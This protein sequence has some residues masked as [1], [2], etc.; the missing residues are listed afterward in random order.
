MFDD[1]EC[2]TEGA[3]FGVSATLVLAT[4]G[5]KTYGIS[6]DSCFTG[7]CVIGEFRATE[8]SGGTGLSL[9]PSNLSKNIFVFGGNS[10]RSIATFHVQ[11][12]RNLQIDVVGG[13]AKNLPFL[14][15]TKVAKT[16]R[17]TIKYEPAV[18]LFINN[19]RQTTW[20]APLPT[21]DFRSVI[22]YLHKNEL[23]ILYTVLRT[24]ASNAENVVD[25]P[26]TH[27]QEIIS[28][29]D[30]SDRDAPTEAGDDTVI[31]NENT[32]N[33]DTN[34]IPMP[35]TRKKVLAMH[36]ATHAN[37]LRLYNT[38]SQ[39]LILNPQQKGVLKE[40]C[41]SAQKECTACGRFGKKVK[42]GTVLRP[43]LVK[44]ERGHI[45]LFCLDSVRDVWSLAVVDEG[46]RWIAL[47]V[48]A[49]KE[50]SDV[51]KAYITSYGSVHGC[52][53]FLFS[54]GDGC[55]NSSKFLSLCDAFGIVKESGPSEASE[56]FGIV[57]RAIGTARLTL[58]RVGSDPHGP[59]TKEE[60]DFSCQLC[61]NGIRNEIRSGG[62]TA[63]QR[64][65]GG[66][67]HL[68]SNFLNQLDT[69]IG[70]VGA[71]HRLVSIKE[72]TQKNFFAALNSEKLTQI[73][74]Q[75]GT[76]NRKVL[77]E[78]FELGELIEF[79]REIE[80]GRGATWRIGRIVGILPSE[81]GVLYFHIDIGGVL[82]RVAPRHIR[83]SS[84]VPVQELPNL[85]T[86]FHEHGGFKYGQRRGFEEEVP[87]PGGGEFNPHV[88]YT[89]GART[90]EGGTRTPPRDPRDFPECGRCDHGTLSEPCLSDF[91]DG[92]V[93]KHKYLWNGKKYATADDVR[94][95]SKLRNVIG[96]NE[97]VEKMLGLLTLDNL[98][99]D[100]EP[101]ELVDDSDSEDDIQLAQESDS[102]DDVEQQFLYTVLQGAV[103]NGDFGNCVVDLGVEDTAQS[104]AKENSQ[105]KNDT[106]QSAAK[107]KSK[108]KVE[109]ILVTEEE[110]GKAE[111]D[112]G[113][114]WLGSAQALKG[115]D[116]YAHDFEELPEKERID[117]QLKAISD[118]D[119]F[120]CWDR[121]SDLSDAEM[122]LHL[123]KSKTAVKLTAG[124]VNKCKV[125]A[126]VLAGKSRYT[127][128]GF[129]DAF[130]FSDDCQSPTV[131][132]LLLRILLIFAL[133]YQWDFV[134][135][136]FSQA[137][138]QT[139]TQYSRE[140]WVAI[141]ELDGDSFRSGKRWRLLLKPVPGTNAAPRGWFD[142][143]SK[144]F[145]GIGF[146]QSRYDKAIFLL[147]GTCEG[148]NVFKMFIPLHVD[149]ALVCG[150]RDT[151]NWFQKLVDSSVGGRWKV[152]TFVFLENNVSTEFV[153]SEYVLQNRNGER[154][155]Q[156]SQDKYCQ[157]K[158]REVDQGLV[159]DK[160]YEQSYRQALGTALWATTHSQS[161]SAYDIALAAQKVNDLSRTDGAALN[162][163]IREMRKNPM[164][165]LI[166]TLDMNK[167]L[168]IITIVDAGMGDS[169]SWVGGQG[170]C[171][172]GLAETD[173]N[174]EN[175][176]SSHFKFASVYVKSGKFKRT[177]GASFDGECIV[178]KDGC[179]V[180]IFIQ[181]FISELE[182][183]LRLNIAQTIERQVS[184]LPEQ[185]R[186]L[187]PVDLFTDSF[188]L[189]R[190]MRA[191]FNTADLSKRRVED[192]SDLR[193]C[194]AFNKTRLHHV[195][196]TS[197][198]T[199]ALTKV[200]HKCTATRKILREM[201]ESG[202]WAPQLSDV[203]LG[204]THKAFPKKK[205]KKS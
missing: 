61:A 65:M 83:K 172:I 18:T 140:V 170:G 16:L 145:I 29:P 62:S 139:T 146:V 25:I 56:S 36:A 58:D 66:D 160:D 19:V 80:K 186:E 5:Q 76:R 118:Y 35:I 89:G 103:F 21:I 109:N 81:D 119:E 91:D 22:E 126:G 150:D 112:M 155:L 42:A 202:K 163:S 181:G 173:A 123:V 6:A 134:S 143:I 196:G 166:P 167:S 10:E 15:G 120:Q 189:V 124:F 200:F 23:S 174:A 122:D 57:E 67:S 7:G 192:L 54:D 8:L 63:S 79:Y 106:A 40:W 195:D 24:N 71:S 14:F 74:K 44:N 68:F 110:K 132:A 50:S 99:G 187:S 17:L 148:K 64:A 78:S 135:I 137:F 171:V 43:S 108:Y 27:A 98:E 184:G 101:G 198:P 127:P 100:A 87:S 156:I 197:N 153:G 69:C 94:L 147:P 142:T 131:N 33:A 121:S 88:L 175:E 26:D 73:A 158:L 191:E 97:K 168:R 75:R 111:N 125:I 149:D 31:V 199:D 169:G 45:D 41:E 30:E 151:L 47:K 136:D 55:F 201:L 176:N 194:I 130:R 1:T 115:M 193:E 178:A 13:T 70:G 92:L 107:G 182:Y 52:H 117:S 28:L 177:A 141:P 116:A 138:F 72:L 165:T 3:V 183:G 190:K 102:D 128:K 85:D 60:W 180:S 77:P 90:P 157:N 82:Y 188:G 2:V 203:Y 51:F 11:G 204:K 12:T 86:L 84:V 59:K 95:K 96:K 185:I 161:D 152:G 38:I 205:S 4:N 53:R 105:R 114:P 37:A 162:R 164:H 20:E 159:A 144:W 154:C 39:T 93:G 46:T 129:K 113:K 34:S 133:R 32:E 49:S 48:V 179:T 9:I 104:A